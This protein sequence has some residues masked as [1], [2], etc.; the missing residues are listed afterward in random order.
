MLATALDGE[1]VGGERH[2]IWQ[3]V[4]A[5]QAEPIDLEQADPTPELSLA[6]HVQRIVAAARPPDLVTRRVEAALHTAGRAEPVDADVESGRRGAVPRDT[7][8]QPGIAEVPDV[9]LKRQ[10]AAGSAIDL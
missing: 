8:F 2:Q 3:Q 9:E 10:G 6:L 5:R 1:L 4:V 7:R